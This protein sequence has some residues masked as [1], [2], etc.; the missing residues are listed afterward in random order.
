[1]SAVV[2]VDVRV[3][4]FQDTDE[5]PLR[6]AGAALLDEDEQARVA[7]F[8]HRPSARAFEVSH[9]IT[10]RL[11]SEQAPVTLPREWRFDTGEWG[12]PQVAV[13]LPQVAFNLSHTHGAAAV[14]ATKAQVALGIDVE[15]VGRA[16]DLQKLARRCYSERE[17]GALPED[18]ASEDF[19]ETFFDLWTLK[20]AF[21]KATGRG[22][23]LGLMRFG[24]DLRQQP[25]DFWTEVDAEG[26]WSFVTWSPAP[27]YRASL[28]VQASDVQVRV[29][30]ALAVPSPV[31]VRHQRG[32]WSIVSNRG[33]RS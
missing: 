5:E 16:S 24:F 19:R 15:Q 22:F 12:K 26:P 3:A 7:R 27:G 13:G 32:C 4:C 28:C 30:D 20:E 2:H 18:G 17:R 1:M 10:R 9:G 6:A 23:S 11:L 29:L 33:T 8:R 31:R 21:M 25:M 14:A